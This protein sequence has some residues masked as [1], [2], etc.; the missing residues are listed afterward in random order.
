MTPTPVAWLPVAARVLRAATPW[1][2]AWMLSAT[3]MLAIALSVGAQRIEDRAPENDAAAPLGKVSAATAALSDGADVRANQLVH[4]IQQPPRGCSPNAGPPF[5]PS[6]T[7][8]MLA[9]RQDRV[10]PDE[11]P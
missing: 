10:C 3:V 11:T 1:L 9:S 8:L 6:I 2:A 7:S 4:T 5:D